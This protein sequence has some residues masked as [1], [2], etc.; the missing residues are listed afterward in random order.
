[1][2]NPAISD[3]FKDAPWMGMSNNLHIHVLGLGGIG[4]N[5]FYYLYKTIPATYYIQDMDMVEE[6]NVG[7]QFYSIDDVGKTKVQAAYDRM[8]KFVG[9]NNDRYI[10]S[11]TGKF[12][13]GD[14]TLDYVISGLDNMK[15][16]KDIYESWKKNPTRKLL[17]DGRLRAEYYEIFIVTPGREEEYEKTLFGDSEAESGPCTFK[18][19][20]YFGGLIGAR[21]TH[22]LVNYL[23]NLAYGEE[24]YALPFMIKEFG[25]LMQF[26][27]K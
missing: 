14:T 13:T 25:N 3:R 17:I 6:L 10:Q 24:L 12:D 4:S 21:I 9:N 27:T 5:A 7:T 15:T 23:S 1:M 20:A 18:Q 26:E 22:V 11:L 19:T 16:R 2:N 8:L